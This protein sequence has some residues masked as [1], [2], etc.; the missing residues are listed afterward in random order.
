[1]QTLAYRTKDENWE[2]IVRFY[3]TLF[4]I[5]SWG[6][7]GCS[8]CDRVITQKGTHIRYMWLCA[9]IGVVMPHEVDGL[10]R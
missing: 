4:L 9:A 2:R 1:M 6:D 7:D 8:S 3:G 10:H 5:N